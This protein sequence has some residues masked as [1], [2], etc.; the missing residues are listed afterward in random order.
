MISF[1]EFK[2]V[3][4]R[5]ARVKSVENHPNADK[6]YVLKIDIGDEER[7]IVAGLLPEEK[8]GC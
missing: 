3:D 8:G 5:I 6:L 2:N 1:D 7:Q 4:I